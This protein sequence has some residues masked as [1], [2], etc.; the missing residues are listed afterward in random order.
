MRNKI[1]RA[2]R[3]VFRE[4]Q[5]DLGSFDYNVVITSARRLNHHYPSKLAE[6]IRSELLSAKA[7]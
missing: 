7:R 5:S 3:E 6:S 2:V 4:I 1:K